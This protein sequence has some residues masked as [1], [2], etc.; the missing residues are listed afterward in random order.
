LP[1][2]ARHPDVIVIGAG[3][4]GP[5]SAICLAESGM[6]VRILSA[7]APQETTSRAGCSPRA[8]PRRGRRGSSVPASSSTASGLRPAR[9]DVRVEEE[10]LGSSRL[11]HSY[12]HGD[13]GVALGCA[14]DVLDL[15][16]RA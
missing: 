16:A 12:G 2:H 4:I 13:T 14:R 3:V 1:G 11:V 15:V 7:A 6:Q 5:T 8:A 9:P 10:P